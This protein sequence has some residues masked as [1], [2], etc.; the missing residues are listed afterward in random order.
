MERKMPRFNVYALLLLMAIPVSVDN[1]S[2]RMDVF[3]RINYLKQEIHALSS[4]GL[5]ARR[6]SESLSREE[7]HGRNKN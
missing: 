3:E 4:I 7:L 6:V 5:L 2:A 1:K